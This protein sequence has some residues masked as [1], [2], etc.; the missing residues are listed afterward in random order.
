MR[1]WLV[2]LL[3][4]LAPATAAAQAPAALERL[5]NS[6]PTWARERLSG[7]YLVLG[8]YQ[9]DPWLNPFYLSGDFDGDRQLDAALLVR[10]VRTQK[11][12]IAV[13]LQARAEPLLVGAGRPL[14][15]GGDDFRWMDAWH[16]EPARRFR[17]DAPGARG[18]VFI[19]EKSESAGGLIAWTGRRFAWTQWGD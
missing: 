16:V 4:G 6:L 7:D 15:N 13:L 3:I 11:R 2:A 17:P 14:G 19:V 10:D 5:A 9:V 18:D 12:G 8:Y 1:L